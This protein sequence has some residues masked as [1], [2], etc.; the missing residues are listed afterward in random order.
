[1]AKG[2]GWIWLSLALVCALSAGVLTYFLLQR[3]NAAQQ[4]AI[5]QALQQA[6]AAPA[7]VETIDLPVAVRE[8]LVDTVITGQDL[9]L[10]AFPVEVVPPSA[11]VD[12]A[13]I[14]GRVVSQ[15]LSAGDLF[16]PA[17]LY[18]GEVASLSSEIEPGRTVMAFPIID[19]FTSVNLFVPNDRVDMLLSFAAEEQGMLTG[20]TVQNVRILRILIPRP[21]DNNPNPAPTALLLELSPAEAVLVKKVKDAG[22][23]IDLALRSPLDNQP[24]EIDPVTNQDLI[25]LMRQGA[26]PSV[27][28]IR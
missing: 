7:P 8:L 18:G 6:A 12:P 17:S 2:K 22:G 24:F 11:L 19:L 28:S 27:G 23:T 26:P 3:Q 10:R 20:Y 25:Q 1:M 16:M 4:A 14:E 5:E 13:Q 15:R 21:T 9:T